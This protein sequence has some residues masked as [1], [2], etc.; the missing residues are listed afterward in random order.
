MTNESRSQSPTVVL[1]I[2]DGTRLVR[3]AFTDFGQA[4]R[5][6]EAYAREGFMVDMMSATGSFLMDFEPVR[7]DLAV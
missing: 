2:S 6:A 5:S 7:R 4:A 1:R 3:Q